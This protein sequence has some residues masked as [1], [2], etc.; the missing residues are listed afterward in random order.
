VRELKR[1]LTRYSNMRQHLFDYTLK[2]VL[3]VFLLGRFIGGPTAEAHAAPA[4]SVQEP[5]EKPQLEI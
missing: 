4:D 2:V 3:L 1:R 5:A